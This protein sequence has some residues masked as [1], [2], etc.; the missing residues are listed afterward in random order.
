MRWTKR[1]D[2]PSEALTKR[3]TPPSSVAM[4]SSGVFSRP[5]VLHETQNSEFVFGKGPA[6]LVSH[7]D[8]VDA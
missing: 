1:G 3:P 7:Q 8:V 2:V 6:E 4:T 5:D